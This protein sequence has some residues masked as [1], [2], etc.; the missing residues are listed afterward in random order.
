MRDLLI[1]AIRDY[2]E[3]RDAFDDERLD[4]LGDGDIVKAIE[5][6]DVLVDVA[7]DAMGIMRYEL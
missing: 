4:E 3:Y 7:R 6:A 5:R 2:L 1:Q